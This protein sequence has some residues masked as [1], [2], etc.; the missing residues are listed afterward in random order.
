MF[1]NTAFHRYNRHIL[2]PEIGYLGQAALLNSSVLV[3]GAGGLGCPALLYLAASGIGKIGVVDYDIVIESDLQR[4]VLYSPF[5]VGFPKAEKA[6]EKLSDQNPMISLTALNEKLSSSNALDIISNYDLVL[7]CSNNF[8]TRYL[9]NDAC[10]MLGK[11]FIYGA[12]NRFEGQLSVFNY[13]DGPTYRCM[14]P[15]YPDK[16]ITKNYSDIGVLG[17]IAGL[18][19]CMMAC[20]AI[21]IITSSGDVLNGKLLLV[22]ALSMNFT[23]LTIARSNSWNNISELLDYE[24]LCNVSN[25][26]PGFNSITRTEV[27]KLLREKYPCQLIDIRDPDEYSDNSLPGSINIPE[28]EIIGRLNEIARDHPVIIICNTGIKS[29][30][31]IRHLIYRFGYKNLLSLKGGINEWLEHTIKN[32]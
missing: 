12:L 8:P 19:G 1:S 15:D 21:K 6:A 26:G 31:L 22:D 25:P 23:L 30:H 27:R 13:N 11:P 16:P 10:V 29:G 9:I 3:V 5:D 28:S 24:E 7:D 17:A 32:D 4:Q 2:L 18:I 20:E 14:A